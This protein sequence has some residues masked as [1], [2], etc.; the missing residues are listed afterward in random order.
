VRAC[1]GSNAPN[2]E[3]HRLDALRHERRLDA[4]RKGADAAAAAPHAF[5]RGGT[6]A[7]AGP[8]PRPSS[9]H[10]REAIDR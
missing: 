9:L 10:N 7:C 4:L 1:V 5:G 3:S 2:Q 8:P 6:T